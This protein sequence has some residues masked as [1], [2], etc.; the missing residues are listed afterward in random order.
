MV[1]LPPSKRDWLPSGHLAW[2]IHDAVEDL[3]VKDLRVD[4]LL[5]DHRPR[6]KSQ[7]P[8]PPRVMLR[9]LIYAYC[10]GTFSSR[11]IA[12]SRT[13]HRIAVSENSEPSTPT[14]IPEVFGAIVILPPTR[15]P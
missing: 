8:C 13:A 9:L 4:K 7:L 14:R 2:F 15:F 3:G 12:A 11:R 1:Q 5:D 10:T 6:G